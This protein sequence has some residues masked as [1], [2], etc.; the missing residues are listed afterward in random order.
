MGALSG[1]MPNFRVKLGT[2]SELSASQ[3]RQAFLVSNALRRSAG[4]EAKQASLSA[5]ER[6]FYATLELSFNR[7]EDHTLNAD[8]V[9]TAELSKAM[10]LATGGVLS[11]NDLTQLINDGTLGYTCQ[12]S[13]NANSRLESGG[14]QRRTRRS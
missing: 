12:Q 14:L 13:L 10:A 1:T 4:L 7:D 2:T 11:T 3:E 6:F 5:S 9:P 8:K